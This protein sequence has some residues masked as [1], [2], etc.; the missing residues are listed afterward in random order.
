[1][2]DKKGLIHLPPGDFLSKEQRQ[3]VLAAD[4]WYI[5]LDGRQ[6][7]IVMRIADFPLPRLQASNCLIS[8]SEY[9][10]L[11]SVTVELVTDDH[12]YYPDRFGFGT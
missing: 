10:K 2:A 1:M 12:K 4:W 5:T 9:E 3:Q 6:K 7:Y 11:Y 8:W